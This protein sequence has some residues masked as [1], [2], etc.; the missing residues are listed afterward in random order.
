VR[1]EDPRRDFA[2]PIPVE[3][4]RADGTV[5]RELAVNLSPRGLCVQLHRPIEIGERVTVAFRLPPAGPE[6]RASGKV[7][8]I[9]HAGQ[10]D[11]ATQIWET[12]VHLVELSEAQSAA[13]AV[14]ASQPTH[15][16]R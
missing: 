16:R 4:T 9:G 6:I 12:G 7:V 5:L 14:F 15:R 13:L 1:G 8:W 10:I 3:M 2:A 11:A